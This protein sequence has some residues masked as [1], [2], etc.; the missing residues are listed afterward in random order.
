MGRGNV[1]SAFGIYEES[2]DWSLFWSAFGAIGGIIGSAATTIAIIVALWQTRYPYKKKLALSFSDSIRVV[3]LKSSS[4]PA[5]PLQ[6]ALKISNCGNRDVY[7]QQWGIA[8]DNEENIMFV[9]HLYA[10]QLPQ[11]MREYLYP[12][13]PYYLP[14]EKTV[15]LYFDRNAFIDVLLHCQKEKSVCE[16]TKIKIYVSDS[17]GQVYYK[18]LSKTVKEICSS[19]HE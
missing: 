10:D 14:V 16:N 3:N 15:L 18:K 12:E 7:I 6:V 2:I 5:V 17:T 9:P 8:L 13:F 11:G 19:S 1:L 4:L